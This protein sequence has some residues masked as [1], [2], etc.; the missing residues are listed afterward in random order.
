[1]TRRNNHAD[2][3]TGKP[4][5]RDVGAGLAALEKEYGGHAEITV[6]REGC[7]GTGDA[8]WVYAKLYS[9]WSTFGDRPRHVARALWPSNQHKEFV[10]LVFRLIHQLDH[11]ADAGRRADADELPF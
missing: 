7:R 4:T 9:G 11:M 2:E 8:I 1:M 10:G 6:D 3:R 5:W